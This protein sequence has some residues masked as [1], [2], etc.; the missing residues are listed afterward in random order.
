MSD[1]SKM[2]P[3]RIVQRCLLFVLMI[4]VVRGASAEPV[5]NIAVGDINSA[6]WQFT[7][8]LSAWWKYVYPEQFVAFEPLFVDNPEKRYELIERGHTR[9]FI[10]PLTS[11]LERVVMNREIKIVTVLWPV[12][13]VPIALG[14]PERSTVG[15]KSD[16]YWYYRPQS[17]ILP[18]LLQRF[19]QP[20]LAETIQQQFVDEG[21]FD[22]SLPADMVDELLPENTSSSGHMIPSEVRAPE[23]GKAGFES[24]ASRM[25][26]GVHDDAMGL[27]GLE[28]VVIC[29]APQSMHEVVET[30]HQGTVFFEMTGP[31]GIIRRHFSRAITVVEP[32]VDFVAEVTA[33]APWIRRV[34][35]PDERFNT[36]GFEMALFAHDSEDP[37]FVARL[38]KVLHQ[39]P[40]SRFPRA[41]IMSQLTLA[42]SRTLPPL[43]LHQ[44]SRSFFDLH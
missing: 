16:R 1:L 3:F 30:Y 25:G 5:I 18:I 4:V 9:L 27:G 44:G 28:T 37:E 34:R 42:R 10:A 22:Q 32:D 20:C 24:A 35:A 31:L 23:L 43:M 2:M 38:L 14:Q 8:E 13:L 6:S 17:T 41:H 36:I 15:L 21:F 33:V 29:L 12:Y 7:L 26:V 19:N 11:N 39:P 40:L